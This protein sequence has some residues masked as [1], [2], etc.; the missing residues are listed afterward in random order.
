MQMEAIEMPVH[1]AGSKS[2]DIT[3]GKKRETN[4]NRKL[5]REKKRNPAAL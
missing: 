1:C 4:R 2:R 3:I 5:Q